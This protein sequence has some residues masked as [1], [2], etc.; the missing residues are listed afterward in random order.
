MHRNINTVRNVIEF[1]QNR[2]VK[3]KKVEIEKMVSESTFGIRLSDM[4]LKRIVYLQ[5]HQETKPDHISSENWNEVLDLIEFSFTYIGTIQPY[6]LIGFDNQEEAE[7]FF[8][9]VKRGMKC[10]AEYYFFLDP[11]FG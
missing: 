11:N 7:M 3:A 6:G 9:K 10:F 4:V 2:A 8:Q 1:P 5:E